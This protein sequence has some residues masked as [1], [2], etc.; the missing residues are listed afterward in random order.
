[1]KLYGSYTS[2]YVR[3]VRIVL[4]ETQQ[5]YEFIETDHAGS[6][7]KSPTKRVPFLEDG[8]LFL[9][10][11]TSIIQHLRTKAGQDFCRSAR[12][13]DQFC[14]VNTALD[15]TLNLFLLKRDGVAVTELPYLQRQ[16]AR[17]QTI[18]KELEQ[19]GITTAPADGPYTDAQLRLACFMGWSLFREQL[20][21][22]GYGNLEGFYRQIGQYAPFAATHPPSS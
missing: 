1:M 20:D 6:S 10:D 13:L 11:S 12:E 2:P 9:T 16:L 7:A 14:M 5:P 18:L 4:Q 19:S 17:V 3:H 15:T 8:D 21:F 22:S